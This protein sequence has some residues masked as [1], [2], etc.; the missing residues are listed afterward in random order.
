MKILKKNRIFVPWKESLAFRAAVIASL[1]LIFAYGL[2][3]FISNTNI[4]S[5]E[6][7]IYDKE[8]TSYLDYN[9]EYIKKTYQLKQHVVQTNL[10]PFALNWTQSHDLSPNCT[11]AAKWINTAAAGLLPAV[12][13]VDMQVQKPEP[14]TNPVRWVSRDTLRVFDCS[15]TFRDLPD[16][17]AFDHS[18]L[19]RQNYQVLGSEL[20]D[21]IIPTLYR[22]NLIG[23]LISFCILAFSFFL[24]GRSFRRQL[25]KVIDGI[26]EWSQGNTLFRFS[27]P[28][29]GEFG[30]ICQQFNLMAKRIEDYRNKSFH[31]EKIA[32]WQGI[33]KK[34]AHEI[35]NP[36]TPISMLVAQLD[37]EYQG[38]DARFKAHLTEAKAM[39][40]EE[41]AAL[42]RL[43][44]HFAHFASLPTPQKTWVDI[45][46]T[47]T[48]VVEL[49]KNAFPGH[50]IRY[51][52]R[53]QSLVVFVDE[54]LIRQVLINL[55]KNA[56]EC[57]DSGLLI[58]VQLAISNTDWTL[59]V[60][61][62]GPGIPMSMQTQIFEP[63]FTT[64][65]EQTKSSGLGLTISQKIVLDHNGEIRVRSHAGSTVFT[66]VMPR[67]TKEY[68]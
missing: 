54:G 33:A 13:A 55:V 12:P 62:D 43:V 18:V 14:S 27:D 5:L 45:V 44:D 20:T 8:V 38:D 35:K 28:L 10:I 64:K 60:I 50:H 19:L 59:Q 17:L 7:I 15:F 47:I 39:I 68:L 51:S 37:R 25:Y 30:L 67:R 4:H 22:A 57:L 56:G 58:E 6:P 29:Q 63:Y 66:I 32:S 46:H 49:M 26:R 41:V 11:D 52:G 42:R 16:L 2:N 40:L 21:R 24:I 3:I 34:M 31:L 48:H 36:L 9:L 53:S 61:D 23:L 65:P 1:L